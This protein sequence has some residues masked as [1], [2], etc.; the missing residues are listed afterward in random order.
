[1]DGPH[2][3]LAL[4]ERD[5]ELDQLRFRK[6]HLPPRAQLDDVLARQRTIEEAGVTV[7]AQRDELA[8]RQAELETDL[9]NTEKRLADLDRQMR[10]GTITASRDLQAMAEQVASMK[11]RQSDIEDAEL[12]IM[13]ELEPVEAR[14]AELQ[15]QWAALDA[16]A[17]R[18]RGELAEAE[19]V[20]DAEIAAAEAARAEATGAVAAP[21]LATYERLRSRLGGV[22][23]APLVGASCGG[24]HL[25]LSASELDHLRRLPPDDVV[26]CD[27]CGR[28]LVR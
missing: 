8:R 20:V 10:S 24:C 18:L 22:G 11:R 16:D 28:I 14:V 19:V 21:L 7:S 1:M 12:A 25:T 9:S 27:Q 4:Q 3:L 5:T 13:E 17:V 2:A 15:A 26:N 6:A 23:V